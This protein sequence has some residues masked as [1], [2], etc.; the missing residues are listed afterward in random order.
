VLQDDTVVCRNFDRAVQMIAATHVDTVVCL[1]VAGAS[2]QTARAMRSAMMSGKPYVPLHFREWL[3]VVAVLWP[4]HQAE[5]LLLWAAT[6]KL[7]GMPR[8]VRS[9]DAVCGLWMREN[10]RLVVATVP[11]LVE[12]PDDV[13]S[14]VGRR[15][16]AGADR[17]RVAAHYIGDADPLAIRW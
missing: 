13:E 14:T 16:M 11:S 9:D 12:H 8:P 17:G 3:P 10:R 5:H 4:K 7:P 1:F 6:A 2:I 15:A